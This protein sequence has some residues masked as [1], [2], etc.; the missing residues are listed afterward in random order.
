MPQPPVGYLPCRNLLPAKL[1]QPKLPA[2][3]PPF[4]Q[5]AWDCSPAA[6]FQTPSKPL[7]LARPTPVRVTPSEHRKPQLRLPIR[8]NSSQASEPSTRPVPR[9]QARTFAHAPARDLADPA[10]PSTKALSLAIQHSDFV[11][12]TT[13]EARWDLPAPKDSVWSRRQVPAPFGTDP[14]HLSATT[15]SHPP[16]ATVACR[17]KSRA[18]K[19]LR[20]G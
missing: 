5:R 4:H 16:R 1:E 20:S 7:P 18:L 3:T 2:S 19:C 6:D 12:L 11:G 9:D 10:T 13:L 14:R 15:P 17:R 8:S